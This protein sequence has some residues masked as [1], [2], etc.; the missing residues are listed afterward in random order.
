M[1]VHTQ[2]FARVF[3]NNLSEHNVKLIYKAQCACLRVMFLQR[4]YGMTL[5]V[6]RRLNLISWNVNFPDLGYTSQIFLSV[7]FVLYKFLC[8]I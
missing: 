7:W 4:C 2:T 6:R 5:E 1:I 8:Y 3:A